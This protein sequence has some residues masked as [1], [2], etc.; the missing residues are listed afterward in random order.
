M[1]SNRYRGYMAQ[2]L[3]PFTIVDSACIILRVGNPTR[4]VA[5]PEE[6]PTLELDCLGL[7]KTLKHPLGTGLRRCFCIRFENPTGIHMENIRRC[8][9]HMYSLSDLHLS[10]RWSYLSWAGYE[11]RYPRGADHDWGADM[12]VVY[13]SSCR[14]TSY[15]NFANSIAGHPPRPPAWPK[16]HGGALNSLHV[17][18]RLMKRPQLSSG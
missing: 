10:W 1:H 13:G 18:L 14:P 17:L 3:C 8:C 7:Y 15:S 12:Y 4:V 16:D 11:N 6:Q 5:T 2:W 9:R